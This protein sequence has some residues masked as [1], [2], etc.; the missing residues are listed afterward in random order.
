[1]KKIKLSE[2]IGR[3]LS[4][5]KAGQSYYLIIMSTITAL[6]TFSF[7]FQLN[8]WIIFMLFPI[9]IVCVLFIGYLMDKTD[10]VTMDQQKTIEM[11]HRYINTADD[12]GNDFYIALMKGIFKWM[13]SIQKGKH[14]VFEDMDNE[15]KKY[16]KKWKQKERDT[17]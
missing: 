16:R 9:G 11:T 17:K 12:K 5:I 6:S 3:Q 4:R 14:I 13:E 15:I 1:L 2:F 7:A 10:V 8:L